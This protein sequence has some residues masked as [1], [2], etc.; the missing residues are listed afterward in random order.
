MWNEDQKSKLCGMSIILE[1]YIIINKKLNLLTITIRKI[2]TEIQFLA[3][4]KL[5]ISYKPTWK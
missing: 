2:A 3:E 4:K 1:Q 5:R